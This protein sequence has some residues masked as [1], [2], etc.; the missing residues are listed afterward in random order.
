MSGGV[1]DETLGANAED[2]GHYCVVLV[3]IVPFRVGLNE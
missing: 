2:I 3:V 1:G